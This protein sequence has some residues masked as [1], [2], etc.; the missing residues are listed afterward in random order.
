METRIRHL[1][2]GLQFRTAIR[3]GDARADVFSGEIASLG[4][5]S[6]YYRT[7]IQIAGT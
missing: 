2:S 5:G 3:A 6:G 7:E 4:T 1:I